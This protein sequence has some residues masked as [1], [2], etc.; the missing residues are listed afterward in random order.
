MG[1]SDGLI[2]KRILFQMLS[3]LVQ[4]LPSAPGKLQTNYDCFMSEKSSAK[5]TSSDTVK[6]IWSASV[7]LE[8][9]TGVK[10]PLLL[11]LTL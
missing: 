5:K 3:L 8:I 1:V 9:C 10:S 6:Q 4:H 2:P 7:S 11:A